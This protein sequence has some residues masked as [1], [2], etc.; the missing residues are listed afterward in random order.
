MQFDHALL[1][2][3]AAFAAPVVLGTIHALEMMNGESR[4]TYICEFLFENPCYIGSSSSP[5]RSCGPNLANGIVTGTRA[6]LYD[7]KVTQLQDDPADLENTFIGCKPLFESKPTD[8]ENTR[9]QAA[10]VIARAARCLD[11]ERMLH[12]STNYPNELG[13]N[14]AHYRLLGRSIGGDE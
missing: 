3:L 13:A 6:S 14:D 12:G 11:D 10:E 7:I 4:L 9:G 2:L 8:D 5:Q 1:V